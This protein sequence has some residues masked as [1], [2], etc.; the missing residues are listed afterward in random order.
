MEDLPFKIPDDYSND[1]GRRFVE[2]PIRR[3][4]LRI[5]HLM[6]LNASAAVALFV[7]PRIKV[8]VDYTV[9][10]PLNIAILI[11]MSIYCCYRALRP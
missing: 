9:T 1:P 6:I 7:I 4:R 3:T 11:I 8:D 2:V 5:W 10:L